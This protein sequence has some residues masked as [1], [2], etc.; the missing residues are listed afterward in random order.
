MIQQFLDQPFLLS[1]VRET[2][3]NIRDVERTVGRLS[4]LSGNARDVIAL[5]LSLESLPDLKGHLAALAKA[6]LAGRRGFA[7]EPDRFWNS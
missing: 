3:A 2:L 4:Q 7:G 6:V 1:S 5:R